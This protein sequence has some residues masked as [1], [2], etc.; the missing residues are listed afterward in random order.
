M[1]KKNLNKKLVLKKET[2]NTLSMNN[3]KGGAPQTWY[4][5]T[6]EPQGCYTVGDCWTFDVRVCESK[7]HCSP[8]EF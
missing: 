7:G 6:F 1:K 8:D 3:V 5:M 2:I 4:C